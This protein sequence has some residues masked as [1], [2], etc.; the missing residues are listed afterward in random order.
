MSLVTP[1]YNGEAFLAKCIDS[2][3]AQTYRNFEYLIV[4]N[5]STDR[6]LEIALD[7][8]GK[9]NRIRVHRNLLLLRQIPALYRKLEECIEPVIADLKR[10]NILKDSDRIL[11][12]NTI[13]HQVRQRDLRS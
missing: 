5:C 1:V 12:K 11:F 7:Y 3:L 8:A 13:S 6:S 9:D 2:V 10:C 4:N